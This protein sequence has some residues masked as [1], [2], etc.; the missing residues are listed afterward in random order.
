MLKITV[1]YTDYNEQHHTE[2]L[3]FHIGKKDVLMAKDD[4]YNTIVSTGQKL[5]DKAGALEEAQANI[6][7]DEPLDSNSLIVAEAVRDLAR[8]LDNVIDLAYGIRTEDGLRFVKNDKVLA[9]FKDSVA[10]DALLDKLLA[11]P[12]EML[13]FIE[14]LMK[15]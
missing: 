14:S 15:Q 5:Q 8:L 9:D 4:V 11:S 2:D 13:S 3:W 10:Y 12:E 6:K 1:D 7:E